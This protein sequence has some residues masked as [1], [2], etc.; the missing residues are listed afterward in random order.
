MA[1]RGEL[2]AEEGAEADEGSAAPQSQKIVYVIHP[3][4]AL[5][6]F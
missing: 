4:C 2:S 6:E 5:E 1:I 3:N